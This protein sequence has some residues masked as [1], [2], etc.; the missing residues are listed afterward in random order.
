[1]LTGIYSE[2]LWQKSTPAQRL[3]SPVTSFSSSGGSPRLSQDRWNMLSLGLPRG[4]LLVG[5]AQNTSTGR[6]PG[7]I[8]IRLVN[9]LNF[10]SNLN[11]F[12]ISKLLNLCQRV[13]PDCEWNLVWLRK[14]AISHYWWFIRIPIHRSELEHTLSKWCS[15]TWC[16]G[17]TKAKR[18]EQMYH[19]IGLDLYSFFS[20]YL[21]LKCSWIEVIP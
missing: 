11:S 20:S 14:S 13:N 12:Q 19:N 2:L 21:P 1:M 9:Q 16:S 4:L 8:L 18:T 17:C 7:G 3:F 5:C 15:L 6:R 10:T